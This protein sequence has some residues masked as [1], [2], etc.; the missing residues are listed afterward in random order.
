[1]CIQHLALSSYYPYASKY[2]LDIKLDTPQSFSDTLEHIQYF[3]VSVL[4]VRVTVA[5][6]VSDP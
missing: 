2:I 4:L 1:M 5:I 6:V 3:P